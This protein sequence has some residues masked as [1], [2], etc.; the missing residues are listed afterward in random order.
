MKQTATRNRDRT[1]PGQ[2]FCKLLHCGT[3]LAAFTA[4]SV[5]H[6]APDI[7]ASCPGADHVATL[8][9]ERN[10][11]IHYAPPV[12]ELSNSTPILII[13]EDGQELEWSKAGNL[14]APID[15]RP[16]RL[17]MVAFALSDSVEITLRPAKSDV[18]APVRIR[19]LCKPNAELAALPAC[20]ERSRKVLNG[21]EVPPEPAAM[22]AWCQALMTQAQ[23][24]LASRRSR[25]ETSLRLYEQAHGEWL[26]AGDTRRAAA[27][28]L[29]AVEQTN[30]LGDFA[31]THTLAIA[32]AQENKAAGN[33]YFSLRAKI[34]QCIALRN[35]GRYVESRRCIEPLGQQFERLREPPDA[36]N[37]FYS[38]ANMALDDGNVDHARELLQ[39]AETN[40]R[41]GSAPL[42]AG[43]IASLRAELSVEDGRAEAAIADMEAALVAFE[44]AGDIRWQA[45]T[46]LAIAELYL[47]LGALEEARL[48]ASKASALLPPDQATARAASARWLI[49]R[50]DHAAGHDTVALDALEDVRNAFERLEMR[51]ALAEVQLDAFEW[52]NGQL[53]LPEPLGGGAALT[54]RLIRRRDLLVAR[55]ALSR[56]NS[57]LANRFLQTPLPR[58]SNLRERLGWSQLFAV[59]EW[60][61][62]RRLPAINSLRNAAGRIRALAEGTRLRSLRQVAARQLLPL[63]REWVDLYAADDEVP[64]PEVLW[65]LIVET[66]PNALLKTPISVT[67]SPSRAAAFDQA[68]A[69]ELR[70]RTTRETTDALAPQRALLKA[71]ASGSATSATS[72]PAI[73]LSTVQQQLPEGTLLLA[74]A[75][76]NE[77]AY[78]LVVTKDSAIV[79]PLGPNSQLRDA[80]ANLRS[81]LSIDRAASAA[82]SAGKELGGHLFPLTHTAPDRLIVLEDPSLDDIPY[83]T[84]Y[85]PN[86]NEPLLE[87]TAV[88]VLMTPTSLVRPTLPVSVGEVVRVFIA[89][90]QNETVEG[91]PS[92]PFA[93]QEAKLIGATIGN[94]RVERIS[95]EDFSVETLL[96]AV[97]Q[98]NALVHVAAH[99]FARPT[100]QAYS[101]IWLPPQT[102]E[103]APRF[104]SWLSVDDRNLNA[105]LVVLNACQLAQ[106]SGAPLTP[107]TSFAGALSAAGVQNVIA[108]LW[109]LS[110]TASATWVPDFYSQL[111]LLDSAEISRALNHAQRSLRRS[112]PFQHPYYWASQIHIQQGLETRIE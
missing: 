29:G 102:G 21:N 57:A 106:R 11:T 104:V 4:A 84:L 91:L 66:L 90:L 96:A 65:Q 88:S 111:E 79:A 94:N 43:R 3:A 89:A 81:T 69:L 92:L 82:L 41:A 1:F 10:A 48:F 100:L 74:F 103:T 14:F 62:G 110:D 93:S 107:T 2:P 42:V 47:N 108:G 68:L 30:K 59:R 52:S 83:A 9:I 6:A 22:S 20:I 28:R 60:K 40:L 70:L 15:T 17:G 86:A 37:A 33:S 73:A 58:W 51:L 72:Q 46:Y 112:R 99:G 95:D 54:P 12:S 85:W 44:T 13:E 101:G 26:V 7:T 63:R 31:I 49:A 55:D 105:R 18:V 32:A 53:L 98:P 75:V 35:L 78:V 34:E 23:A 50:I 39:R 67:R 8:T 36:A 109:A 97:E 16:P 27:T 71:W 19:L 25:P 56:G 45:N 61:A 76:G 38:A 24:T 87:S 5:A 64:A 80:L 77:R